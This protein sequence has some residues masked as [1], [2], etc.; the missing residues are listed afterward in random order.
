M[1][2]ISFEAALLL[3]PVVVISAVTGAVVTAIMG[4]WRRYGKK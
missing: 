3:I 1:P 4:R 2:T